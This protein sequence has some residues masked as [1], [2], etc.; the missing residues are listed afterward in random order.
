[1]AQSP[2]D[3]QAEQALKLETLLYDLANIAEALHELL[4]AK[5]DHE[6]SMQMFEDL[7]EAITN[8]GTKTQDLTQRMEKSENLS[9]QG[10][11]LD[12]LKSISSQLSRIEARQTALEKNQQTLFASLRLPYQ[13]GGQ[14]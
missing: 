5:K 13:T 2:D 6:A 4:K 10:K 7:I 3:P 12:D 11:I 14:S 9:T 1:M 8:L